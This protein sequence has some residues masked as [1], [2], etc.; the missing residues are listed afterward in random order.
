MT[1]LAVEGTPHNV[2]G[3]TLAPGAATWPADPVTT[4]NED[5]NSPDPQQATRLVTPVALYACSAN[6]PDGNSFRQ[7]GAFW[8]SSG[9]QQRHC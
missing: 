5:L 8:S 2:Q 4:R 9:L 7:A 3:N 6:A 1:L